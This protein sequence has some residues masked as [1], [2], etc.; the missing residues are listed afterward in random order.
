M[1]LIPV[2]YS[3]LGECPRSITRKHSLIVFSFPNPEYWKDRIGESEYELYCTVCRIRFKVPYPE[4]H[5]KSEP[6]EDTADA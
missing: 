3:G 1:A 2:D 5:K 4:L 6:N